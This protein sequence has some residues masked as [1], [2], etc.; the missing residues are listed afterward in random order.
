MKYEITYGGKRSESHTRHISKRVLNDIKQIDHFRD[1]L[2]AGNT[3]HLQGPDGVNFAIETYDAEDFTRDPIVITEHSIGSLEIRMPKKYLDINSP[4]SDIPAGL[5]EA[6]SLANTKTEIDLMTGI[7]FD[8]I[9]LSTA[10]LVIG[11]TVEFVVSLLNR[12]DRI[13]AMDVLEASITDPGTGQGDVTC[14]LHGFFA[15]VIL[16]Q[17]YASKNLKTKRVEEEE[18]ED[19][20]LPQ[21]V[22]KYAPRQIPEAQI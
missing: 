13:E 1:E 20:Q 18:E 9:P 6:F 8:R 4:Y 14:D 15:W 12:P 16:M 11:K 2:L 3:C 7:G 22:R 17:R 21:K 5:N 19:D 10:C